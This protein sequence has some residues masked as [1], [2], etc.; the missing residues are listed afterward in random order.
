MYKTLDMY[1]ATIAPGAVH[2]IAKCVHVLL[3]VGCWR[4]DWPCSATGCCDEQM[5]CTHRGLLAFADAAAFLNMHCYQQTSLLLPS[6]HDSGPTGDICH[7]CQITHLNQ[8]VHLSS[9]STTAAQ[10]ATHMLQRPTC[11]SCA[12]AEGPSCT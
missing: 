7:D 6:R 9:C 11:C 12:Y 3:C 10:S 1:R 8:S 4:T 5:S 2:N